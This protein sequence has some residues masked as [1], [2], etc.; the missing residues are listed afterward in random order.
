MRP[1]VFSWSAVRWQRVDAALKQRCSF[2]L[3][4]LRS[5]HMRRELKRHSWPLGQVK[6]VRP[7]TSSI[8]FSRES[9]LEAI[10][11]TRWGFVLSCASVGKVCINLKRTGGGKRCA[12]PK[13]GCPKH[14]PHLT[15][16]NNNT[17]EI[18]CLLWSG[19]LDFTQWPLLHHFFYPLLNT[20]VKWWWCVSQLA[21]TQAKKT[22]KKPKNV[23]TKLLVL[24]NLETTRKIVGLQVQS[25]ISFP[26]AKYRKKNC[27]QGE[28][29]R[30]SKR[31][32]RSQEGIGFPSRSVP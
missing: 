19:A 15:S 22:N 27:N 5:C 29:Q 10:R 8:Q 14:I 21:H 3:L 16:L 7:K 23:P 30:D 28:N 24:R 31:R 12:F 18:V 2:L 13:R 20:D 25:F 4:M 26:M 6:L 1:V 32:R 17:T 11:L 9:F